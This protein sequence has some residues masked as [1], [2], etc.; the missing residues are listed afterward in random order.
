MTPCKRDPLDQPLESLDTF[1]SLFFNISYFQIV[2]LLVNRFCFD[3][4]A[5]YVRSRLKSAT[6]GLCRPTN[7]RPRSGGEWRRPRRLPDK[8][9]RGPTPDTPDPEWPEG[10]TTTPT[11]RRTPSQ[12]TSPVPS[13]GGSSA[14]E[15]SERSIVSRLQ[16]VS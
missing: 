15:T 9:V 12:Q 14:S 4:F 7:P 11:P 10:P 5:P 6:T 1:F 2:K 8:A 16:Q 3:R 13:A